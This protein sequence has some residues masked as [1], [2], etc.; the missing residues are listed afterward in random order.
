[1]TVSERLELADLANFPRLWSE[2]WF[3][4]HSCTDFGSPQ[5]LAAEKK[6][7]TLVTG[8][9]LETSVASD[10][11]LDSLSDRVSEEPDNVTFICWKD[12]C[13]A[14]TTHYEKPA[15]EFSKGRRDKS[16]GETHFACAQR[17]FEEE[18]GLS[19]EQ[20][21]VL[22]VAPLREEFIGINGCRYVYV[23]YLAEMKETVTL[24]PSATVVHPSSAVT[25]TTIGESGCLEVGAADS[26]HVTDKV[27][28]EDD[29]VWINPKNLSQA[30][31]VSE[32]GWRTSLE[33]LALFRPKDTSRI[34][35]FQEAHGIFEELAKNKITL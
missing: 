20:Y 34:A 24:L 32:I 2:L 27:P 12:L 14:Q 13:A 17:E 10:A 16:S 11:S 18:T 7:R 30:S 9:R 15:L 23:Y 3:D 1:M 26:T 21:T 19:K 35:C 6:L 29:H 28:V 8:Y 5:Y 31:E 22:N 4:K 25:R 33:I